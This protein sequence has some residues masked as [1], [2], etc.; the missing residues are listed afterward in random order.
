MMTRARSLLWPAMV[1]VLVVLSMGGTALGQGQGENTRPTASGA[2][3]A[4]PGCGKAPTLTSGTYTI[5]SG[6][7]NRSFILRV[8]DG[9]D[10]SRA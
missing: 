1:A 3:A 4:S 7:R 9:Y 10:R 2:A 5:Q 6:G 8:P